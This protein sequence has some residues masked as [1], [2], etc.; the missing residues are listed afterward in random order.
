MV[1]YTYTDSTQGA[2]N[3]TTA[4]NTVWADNT[5]TIGSVLYFESIEE[6]DWDENE[7]ALT[8]G[9]RK[10]KARML[11][12]L[13]QQGS[14]KE[15]RTRGVRRAPFWGNPK[16]AGAWSRLVAHR[17][18]IPEDVGSNPTASAHK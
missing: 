3:S 18:H 9:E 8:R 17:V 1:P 13:A 16:R 4:A 10:A 5:R 12:A 15:M 7:P 14:P 11:R 6:L 2:D